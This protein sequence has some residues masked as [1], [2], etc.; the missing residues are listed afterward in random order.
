AF[1]AAAGRYKLRPVEVVD[2]PAPPPPRGPDLIKIGI[3]NTLKLSFADAL[4]D[5]DAAAAEAASGGGAGLATEQPSDLYLYRAMATAR[6]AGKA[7]AAA[8]PT[9]ARTRAA[10]D[11]LRAATMTPGRTLNPRELP[12]QAVADFERAAADVRQKPRGTLVVTGSADAQ[13]AL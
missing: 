11:Y 2:V 8:P 3:I 13:V 7:T 12:P 10:A 4:R 5:L 6:V 1:T 9:E